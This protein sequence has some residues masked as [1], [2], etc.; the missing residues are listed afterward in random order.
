[1]VLYFGV[2]CEEGVS[3]K[4]ERG[5]VPLFF[6]TSI[7]CESITFKVFAIPIIDILK[8]VD[9]TNTRLVKIGV[10]ES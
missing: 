5:L 4:K 10:F 2:R 3:S 8:R 6:F 7:P 1:M 9:K